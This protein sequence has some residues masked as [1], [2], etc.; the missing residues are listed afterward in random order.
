MNVRSLLRP[1]LA[2]CD[3]ACERPTA[4]LGH[5]QSPPLAL[6]VPSRSRPLVSGWWA[7]LRTTGFEHQS[8][9]DLSSALEIRRARDRVINVLGAV[10]GWL[11]FGT[12]RFDYLGGS[13]LQECLAR[14]WIG[15]DLAV[16]RRQS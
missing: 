15:Y 1:T 10:A 2:L 6:Q 13:A 14:G 11:P 9:V 4:P 5:R 8:T 7:H 3:G 16:F 12:G